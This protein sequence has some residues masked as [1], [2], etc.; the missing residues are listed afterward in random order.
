MFPSE[1]IYYHTIPYIS[2]LPRVLAPQCYRN[3]TMMDFGYEIT[4]KAILSVH[5][6]HVFYI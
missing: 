5:Y 2:H 6:E 1:T 3:I 4:D